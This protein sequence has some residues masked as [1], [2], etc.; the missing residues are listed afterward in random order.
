MARKAKEKDPAKEKNTFTT[1][2][3]PEK[4]R[5]IRLLSVQTDREINDLVDEALDLLLSKY[6][7]SIPRVPNQN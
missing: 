6:E 4:Y 7:R 3:D 2:V 1:F 5:L